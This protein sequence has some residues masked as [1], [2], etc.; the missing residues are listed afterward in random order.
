M[1]EA[2]QIVTG[3]ENKDGMIKTSIKNADGSAGS[4]ATTTQGTDD[5]ID[6][7]KSNRYKELVSGGMDEKSAR[8]QSTKDIQQIYMAGNIDDYNTTNGRSPTKKA[9]YNALDDKDRISALAR[10]NY[11]SSKLDSDKEWQNTLAGRKS[12]EASQN[13]RGVMEEKE[14][15]TKQMASAKPLD[16]PFKSGSQVASTQPTQPATPAKPEG[17][18]MPE[19][20]GPPASGGSADA[21]DLARKKKKNANEGP[22]VA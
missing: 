20:S 1:G 19:Y 18:S 5:K 11:D 2:P 14:L 7:L 4:M 16:V 22:M 17:T 6:G 10:N 13:E 21:S 8:K 3:R 12:A 9:D 15:E